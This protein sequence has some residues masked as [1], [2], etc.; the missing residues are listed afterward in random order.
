[1]KFGY[2][3]FIGSILVEVNSRVDILMLRI[4]V[5]DKNVGIYSFS[6]LFAEG[7]YQILTILQNSYNPIL[8][9]QISLGKRILF[10][11]S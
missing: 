5:L 10:K 7:F 9:K 3:S 11:I 8:S 1:M 6:A 4:I 2:K